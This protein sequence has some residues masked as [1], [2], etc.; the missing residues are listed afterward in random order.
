MAIN[1]NESSILKDLDAYGAHADELPGGVLNAIF[2]FRA[3][4]LRD[5]FPAPFPDF[6]SALEALQSDTAYLAELSGELVAYCRDGRSFEIP[7]RFFIRKQARF[8]S[9][10][11]AEQW[12][13]DRMEA[14]ERGEP[15][16]GVPG[17]ALAHPDDPIDKQ[18]DDA[19]AFSDRRLVHPDNNDEICE[20]VAHW[21]LEQLAPPC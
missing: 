3:F 9:R 12:I 4:D 18:I 5:R 19:M 21:L 11:E 8:E 2:A 1:T 7:P 20:Q 6:R 17:I 16:A 15:L 14:I 10:T 13:R